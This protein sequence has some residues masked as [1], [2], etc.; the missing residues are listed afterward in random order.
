MKDK[1]CLVN[2]NTSDNSLRQKVHCSSS[3]HWNETF[4][5]SALSSKIRTKALEPDSLWAVRFGQVDYWSYWSFHFIICKIGIITIQL[6]L[7]IQWRLVP[8]S[9]SNTR[10]HECSTPLYKKIYLPIS[11]AYPLVYFKS[12]LGYLQYLI[13]CKCYVTVYKCMENSSFDI[14]DFLKFLFW[15]FLSCIWLCLQMWNP[16]VQ[17]A[18]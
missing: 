3:V 5:T 4:S 2:C 10:I 11:S 15:T 8:G 7:R 14:W 18:D 9:S 17:M 16:W 6:S 12:S 13:Q 1:R